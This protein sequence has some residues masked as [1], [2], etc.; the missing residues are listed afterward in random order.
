M[1]RY[2]GSGA[3][4]GWFSVEVPGATGSVVSGFVSGNGF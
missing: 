3:A 2:H 1:E 4:V